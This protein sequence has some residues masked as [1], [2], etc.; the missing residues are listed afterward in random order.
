MPEYRQNLQN[1]N[2]TN[3]MLT[4]KKHFDPSTK[5]KEHER[6]QADELA[7][8]DK[9]VENSSEKNRNFFIVYLTF[10]VYVQGII[11]STSDYQLLVSSEGLK[12]PLV[13][14]TVS[15]NGFYVVIP[16]FIIAL[17]FNFLQ[18]LESHHYK[19]LYWKDL[20]ITKEIPRSHI[21]P[22]LFDFAIL[23]GTQFPV[24]VRIASDLLCFEFALI[25]LGL[26]LIRFSD[27]QD[28]LI[29]SW[30]FIFFL[31]DTILLWKFQNALRE[32]E[33][34]FA[35]VK[36]LKYSLNNYCRFIFG[37]LI[38]V[39]TIFAYVVGGTSDEY[40]V[41]NHQNWLQPIFYKE[42]LTSKNPVIKKLNL[43]VNRPIEWFLPRISIHPSQQLWE[44][45]KSSLEALANLEGYENWLI[46]FKE[47]G[48]GFRPGI[49]GLRF[50]ELPEQYLPKSDLSNIQLQGAN[51]KKTN[52][53]GANLVGSQLQNA[54][55]KNAQM[56]YANLLNA[57]LTDANL[58]ESQLQGANLEMAD[59]KKANLIRSQI[60][61]ANLTGADF[62]SADLTYSQM[63]GAEF[64][65]TK[66][67]GTNLYRS[68]MDGAII[69]S[70]LTETM[71]LPVASVFG[72]FRNNEQDPQFSSEESQSE[73]VGYAL[74]AICSHQSLY[75]AYDTFLLSNRLVSAQ[76]FR[77]RFINLGKQKDIFENYYWLMNNLPSIISE[78]DSKLCT[79]PECADIKDNIEGLDCKPFEKAPSSKAAAKTSRH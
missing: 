48:I 36:T 17:H 9:I 16:I 72:Y 18:N 33:K 26:L 66:M 49:S 22:F 76:A 42:F 51:L 25:T 23:G 19:L 61:G 32:N 39:E 21:N 60:Q 45:N 63:Q 4:P 56:Q 44:I 7:R 40:F 47:N 38:F 6:R 65:G 73:T 58:T 30:H 13:D 78:I 69:H 54:I 53:R 1:V 20:Q 11:F 34:Q 70:K 77:N 29:T 46:Y 27:Q 8:M 79:L 10:L 64:S 15:L 31:I 43:F 37:T 28:F 57:N 35:S 67:I 41:K 12:L 5:A 2:K 75:E 50:A 24:L 71:G 14:L 59:L 55:L 62:S 74:G 68:K 3:A 52:L